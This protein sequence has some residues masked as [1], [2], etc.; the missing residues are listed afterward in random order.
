MNLAKNPGKEYS[1]GLKSPK[2]RNDV[3][4]RF[5][6]EV[7]RQLLLGKRVLLPGGLSIEI[8]RHVNDTGK[9]QPR[10]GF[11]YKVRMNYDKLKLKKIK[12]T[13][14]V[15]LEKKLNLILTKTDFEYKLVS[16]GYQ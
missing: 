14:T 1:I 2:E 6:E 9:V 5:H 11:N 4:L 16:H 15:S 8:I 12:F 7:V 3:V 13:P 10:L